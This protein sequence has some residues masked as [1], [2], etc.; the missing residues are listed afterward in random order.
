[1]NHSRTTITGIM[2]IHVGHENFKTFKASSL[3]KINQP[4][5]KIKIKKIHHISIRLTRKVVKPMEFQ[6]MRGRT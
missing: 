5:K 2:S 6:R 1:M 4:Y 3:K